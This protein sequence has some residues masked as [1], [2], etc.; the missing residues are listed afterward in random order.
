MSGSAIQTWLEHKQKSALLRARFYFVGTSVVGTLVLV[1]NAVIAFL[2]FKLLFLLVFPAIPMAS[3]AAALL[4]VVGVTA[5]FVDCVRA[6]RDDMAIIPFWLARE[7]FHMGPRTIFDGWNELGRARQLAC[8][9]TDMC[10]QLLGYL[11]TKVTPTRREELLRVFPIWRWDEMVRQLRIVEGVI[12]FRNEMCVSLLTPLRLELRQLLA[13]FQEAEMPREEIP[14]E[15]P[16]ASPIN[17]PHKLSAHEIL[18]V[19]PGATVAEIKAAYR[20]RIKDCHP[21]RFPHTDAKSRALAEEWTKALNI[22]YAELLS[23]HRAR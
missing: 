16:E 20:I 4:S 9:D 22:A 12:V 11:V 23:G 21:D 7:Y 10:A 15:Q 8:L 13:H 17:E 19:S 18:S 5:L 6:E 2:V 14:H 3:V 1:P